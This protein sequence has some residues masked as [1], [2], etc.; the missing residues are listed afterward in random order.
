MR[1][2]QSSPID[3]LARAAGRLAFCALSAAAPFM[4]SAEQCFVERLVRSG[5]SADACYIAPCSALMYRMMQPDGLV[6]EFARGRKDPQALIGAEG[7]T[8]RVDGDAVEVFAGPD[9]G[10]CA[11]A[12]L[13]FRNGRLAGASFGGRSRAFEIS[14]VKPP[15]VGVGALWPSAQEDGGGGGYDFDIWRGKGRLRLWFVNPNRAGAFFAELMVLFI[16]LSYLAGPG[17]RGLAV[18]GCIGAFASFGCVLLTGSRSSFVAAL[19]ALAVL[20]LFWLRRRITPRRALLALVGLVVCAG[21]VYASP[22]SGR[23]TTRLF[24]MDRANKVRL[25][26]LA[27]APRMIRDAPGGWGFIG[28][29]KAYR[30]WYLSFNSRSVPVT[31]V[32]DHLTRVVELGNPMRVA[33]LAFWL[34]ILGTMTLAAFRGRSAIPLALWIVLAVSGVFNRTLGACSLW[35]APVTAVLCMCRKPTGRGLVQIGSVVVASLAIAAALLAFA[36]ASGKTP[37][38]ALRVKAD[39][40]RVLL[41]GDAPDCWI[42]D[43]GWVFGGG[44]A[45]MEMRARF[46]EGQDGFP[47]GYVR[48]SLDLPKRGVRRLVL[49]GKAGLEFLMALSDGKFP[50]DFQVP[51]EIVF[52]SPC[53]PP[54]VIPEIMLRNS[55]V[56]LFIGEFAAA[57]SP[58]Y[59]NPPSWVTVVEGAELYIPNWLGLA[60]KEIR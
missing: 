59:E 38:G 7:W 21:M 48:S 57:Q 1:S 56:R 29:G 11:G 26:N 41:N 31:L 40:R 9:A 42:V 39:G 15:A 44:I 43:D 16:A 50:D 37:D 17:R 13:S 32:S 28:A 52:V 18:V 45:S 60:K 35:A 3:S 12:K 34:G 24:A 6:R 22:K 10:D 23:L 36:L 53:F 19:S 51:P 8:G 5:D 27:A 47:V 58:E 14:A 4:A 55:A 20:A 33:Y 54:S 25:R 2:P 46:V 30:N 49:G